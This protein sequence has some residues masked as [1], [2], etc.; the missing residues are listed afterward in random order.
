M[1][2]K[3]LSEHRIAVVCVECGSEDVEVLAW[4][5]PNRNEICGLTGLLFCGKG[6]GYGADGGG[7]CHQCGGECHTTSIIKPEK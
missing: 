3:A 2:D 6:Y 4:V 5:A 1:N 7:L